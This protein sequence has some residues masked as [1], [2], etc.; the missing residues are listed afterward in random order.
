MGPEGLAYGVDMTE[1]MLELARRNARDAGV[2]SVRFLRD[3]I[4]AAPLPAASVDVVISNCVINLSVD[5]PA[6][7]GEIPRVLRPG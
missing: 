2:D 4:E 5:T 7:L 6:V 3:T 1:E